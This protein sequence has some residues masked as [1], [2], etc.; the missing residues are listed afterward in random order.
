MMMIFLMIIILIILSI[1]IR[2]PPLVLPLVVDPI[3]TVSSWAGHLMASAYT[4]I[5]STMKIKI[6]T[7][8]MMMVSMLMIVMMIAVLL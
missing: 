8:M 6:W 7:M 1:M 2:T 4:V 5:R 3:Y